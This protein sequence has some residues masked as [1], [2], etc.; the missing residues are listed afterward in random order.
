MRFSV[1]ILWLSESDYIYVICRPG[2]PY[3]EKLCSRTRAQ[4]L[5]NK[6]RPRPANNVFIFLPLEN[7]FVKNICVDF[8][9]NSFTPCACVDISVKQTVLFTEVF[10]RRDSV[11]A[12]FRTEQ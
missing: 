2:G 5:P 12:D 7:Y 11:F 9:R 10:K 6:D 3:W 8:Y 1:Y 4:F